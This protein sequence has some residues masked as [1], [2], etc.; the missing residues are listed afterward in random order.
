MKTNKLLV[1]LA[2]LSAVCM[3]SCTK[4]VNRE[5]EAETQ[6]RTIPATPGNINKIPAKLKC[7]HG[8]VFQF[9]VNEVKWADS[10][11]W[12]ITDEASGLKDKVRT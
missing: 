4:A 12:K 3:L 9:S 2:S 5:V 1:F 7:V 8:E 10:Y 6:E 11:E